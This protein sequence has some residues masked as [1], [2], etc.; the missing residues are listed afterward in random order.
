MKILIEERRASLRIK[1]NKGN[2]ACLFKVED[3]VKAHIQVQ[4]NATKGVVS[5]FSYRSRGPFV[6]TKDIGHNSFEVQR[7]DEPSLAKRKY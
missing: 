2:Q 5:K 1:Q 4:Y 7:Y 6:I 3:I